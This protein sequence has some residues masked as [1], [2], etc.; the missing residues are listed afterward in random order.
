MIC[1]RYAASYDGCLCSKKVVTYWHCVYA[2]GFYC[3]LSYGDSLMMVMMMVLII[4]MMMMITMM[5]MMML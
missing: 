5:L 4:I 3:T 2:T 1:C